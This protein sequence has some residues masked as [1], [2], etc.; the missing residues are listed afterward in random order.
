MSVYKIKHIPT[1]LFWKGGG[2]RDNNG[3]GNIFY[4]RKTSKFYGKALNP[5]D[6]EMALEICFSKT[7]KVWNKEA[8]AI[9][10]KNYGHEPGLDQILKECEIIKYELAK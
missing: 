3:V 4:K 9:A 6:P 5:R 10:E 1:G 7:G 8:W 2:M